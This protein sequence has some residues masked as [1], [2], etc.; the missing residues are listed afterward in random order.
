M[1][2]LS[3]VDRWPHFRTEVATAAQTGLARLVS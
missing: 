2:P 3:R 1:V